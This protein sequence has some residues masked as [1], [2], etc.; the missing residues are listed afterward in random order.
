MVPLIPSDQMD[1]TINGNNIL[2]GNSA[3]ASNNHLELFDVIK[4]IDCGDR[5]II[6]PLS[7]GEARYREKIISHLENGMTPITDF[8]KRSDYMAMLQACS[9]V[10]MNH[11]R[12]QAFG[13]IVIM[14]HMGAK[15]YLRSK[16]PLYHRLKEWGVTVFA[17]EDLEQDQSNFLKPI[18]Q[19]QADKNRE[20]VAD[21]YSLEH[22]CERTEKLIQEVIRNG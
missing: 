21:Y 9:I 18:T 8:I 2:L 20:V 7:Y 11:R 4:K 3:T 15:L 6:V 14:L 5:D 19:E 13:T 17:I 16:N 1:K 22:Y 10:L 12:Q